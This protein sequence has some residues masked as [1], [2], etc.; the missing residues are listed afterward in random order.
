MRSKLRVAA[1]VTLAVGL[2]AGSLY[3]LYLDQVIRERFAGVRWAVPSKVFAAPLELYPGKTMDAQALARE[4]DR[5]GYRKVGTP[6]KPGSYAQSGRAVDLVSRAFQYWDGKEPSRRLFVRFDASGI[7]EIVEPGVSSSHALVR[8]DPLA[9]G[10]I[11]AARAEDRLLLR[12]EEVPEL[13]AKGIILVE[14]R[15]FYSHW[16]VSLRGIAR[17]MVANIKAG[18]VVQGGSTITQQLVRNFFLTLDQ[19]LQRKIKEAIMAILLELH[20]DKEEVLEAYINEIFLG[21]DG[22]RAIHGFGLAAGHYFNKPVSELNAAETALLI[23]LAKGASYY[24]PRRHPERARGRRDLVLRLFRD[25]GLITEETYQRA[26]AA[27]LGVESD[28]D[29]GAVRYP[30]FVDLV[31]RQ[32]EADY[33]KEDLQSEGLRIFTTLDPHAQAELERHIRDGLERIEAQRG[34][35][36]G[37]LEAA[38]LITRTESGEV[39]ALAG[40]REGRY[41]GFNRALDAR[42]PIG[43][44]AKPFVYHTALSQPER[45]HLYSLLEDKP[46][47]LEMPNGSVWEPK[48]YDAD[49]VYGEVRLYEALARS[50]NLA[51]AHLGLAVTPK[52]VAR[53]M[54]AAGLERAPAALPSLALGAIDLSPME[55]AQ[56]F[57]TLAS[58]GF[59]YPLTGIREV[60]DAQGEPLTRYGMQ[61]ERGLDEAP[62]YL[63]NWALEQVAIF[64]T[65]SGVY[66]WIEP[67]TRLAGKTGTTDGYRDAWFA[68]FGGDRVGVFWVGRDDNQPTGLSGASGALPLWSA[69]MAALDLQSY[70][71]F[72]PSSVTQVQIDRDSGLR[73]GEGCQKVISLPFIEGFAPEREAPCAG[74]DTSEGVRGWFQRLWQ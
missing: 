4:L 48:N 72:M 60:T 68:G 71:P 54:Q 55:V 14:D 64:G 52:A 21:Q 8:I 69:T 7:R 31:R 23:S 40:G 66:R 47:R 39:A 57:S 51:T 46:L 30:A 22:S 16:G 49:A 10:S 13:L 43:S 44:L 11:H 33:R 2:V 29:G 41:R 38:A 5:L 62:T 61:V 59:R 1:L 56:M 12:R 26:V 3:V 28:G 15:H 35:E 67:S 63:T 24:N 25:D 70:D 27:P 17:A 37:S 74:S 65:G 9:I 53:T 73:A 45:F 20:Y 42:R 50:Y 18:R 6:S 58:G 36:E 34:I 19:N 32:L